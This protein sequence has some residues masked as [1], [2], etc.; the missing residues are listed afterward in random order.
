M[1]F[2]GIRRFFGGE[3]IATTWTLL[4]IRKKLGTMCIHGYFII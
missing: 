4:E 1:Y 3:L 2:S